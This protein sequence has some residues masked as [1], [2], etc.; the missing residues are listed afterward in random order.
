MRQRSPELDKLNY[1]VGAW[2][3]QGEMKPGPMGPGG[4][5]TMTEHNAWMDGGFFLIL[6]SEFNMAPLGNGSAI[7]FMGYDPER[8]VYT[9]D[10]FD[11]MGRAEHS[12]GALDG[13]TWTWTRDE[14]VDGKDVKAR[15]VMQVISPS[16][17][18]F[19]FDLSPDGIHWNTSME[20]KADKVN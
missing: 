19:R 10:E 18:A 8:K 6:R 20:G 11:S 17:Y 1:F 3:S 15:Y 12:V 7:A 9:Y 5:M 13:N 16:A 4:R 14:R 2:N